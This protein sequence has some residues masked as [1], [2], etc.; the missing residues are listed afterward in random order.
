[1]R[2]LKKIWKQFPDLRFGQLLGNCVNFQQLYYFSDE[3]LITFIERTYAKVKTLS[4]GSK[5]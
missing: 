5:K 1:M 4:G 3:E 2:R